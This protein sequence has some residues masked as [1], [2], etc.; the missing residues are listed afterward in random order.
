MKELQQELDDAVARL[1]RIQ[2]E[3]VGKI[4]EMMKT[5]PFI[6]IEPVK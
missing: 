5:M 3:Q 6:S 1:N 2:N 4:N